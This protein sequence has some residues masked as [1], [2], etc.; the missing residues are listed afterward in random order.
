[1]SIAR[2]NTSH[3]YYDI[4]L[5]LITLSGVI[6]QLSESSSIANSLSYFTIQSNLLIVISLLATSFLSSTGLG[7][8]CNRISVQSAITMYIIIVSLIYNFAI[9]STWVQPYPQ[10]IYDNILHVITPFFY[11]LRWAFFVSKGTLK[12]TKGILWLIYPLTYLAYSVIRGAIVGWYPY[13]FVDLNKITVAE[14]VRNSLLVLGVFLIISL[15]IIGI[16]KMTGRMC[17]KK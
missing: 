2:K 14:T 15:L 11:V 3:R 10:V 16:D 6:L 13:F 4:A 17:K 8:F 7:R 12:W 1:M 9:R 5:M